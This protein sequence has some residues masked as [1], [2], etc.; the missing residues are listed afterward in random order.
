M[1]IKNPSLKLL[2]HQKKSTAQRLAKHLGVSMSLLADANVTATVS[3]HT[4]IGSLATTHKV[5][6]FFSQYMYGE[7]WNKKPTKRKAYQTIFQYVILEDQLSRWL[8]TAWHELGHILYSPFDGLQVHIAL[9]LLEDARIERLVMATYPQTRGAITAVTL[10]QVSTSPRYDKNKDHL[11][12]SYAWMCGKE[13]VPIGIRKEA[14]KLIPNTLA[15]R[16]DRIFHEYLGMGSKL[17]IRR[18]QTLGDELLELLN[19]SDDGQLRNASSD[20]DCFAGN[21][22]IDTLPDIQLDVSDL[23]DLGEGGSDTASDG[24]TG[25]APSTDDQGEP[26]NKGV[27]KLKLIKEKLKDQLTQ[28]VDADQGLAKETA[29]LKEVMRGG[30]ALQA[31]IDKSIE[32][33]PPSAKASHLA[34]E[35]RRVAARF[36]DESGKGL[37]R[38]RDSGRLKPRRYE[39]YDDLDIAYDQWEPGLDQE[40]MIG[41]AMDVS[42]SMIDAP[43]NEALYA[44]EVGLSDVATV[45]VAYFNAE[46]FK[47]ERPNT[48]T[49][50]NTV[51]P[52]GGTNP[53]ETVGYLH[54][55][56]TSNSTHNRLLVIYTDGE[57]GSYEYAVVGEYIRDLFM[58]GIHVK[59]VHEMSNVTS[60]HTLLSTVPELEP[61]VYR[62][63]G[64]NNLADI[65]LDWTRTVLTKGS[66]R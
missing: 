2:E 18:A 10:W 38:R 56:L 50:M 23:S 35:V 52:R 34:N 54:G 32:V 57:W 26:S 3:P 55:V 58:Q 19:L 44:L 20:S 14:R 30:V 61:H 4:N 51:R 64:V 37:V 66:G 62:T 28:V 6:S 25:D 31:D 8:G 13:H 65:V 24:G 49:S 48:R 21:A 41:I 53:A 45:E 12:Y 43:V 5:G 40:M 42:G 17:D 11:A 63:K 16:I 29:E 7:W 9:N 15:D 1:S 59:L 46:M 27:K 36:N 39:I 22:N 47:S 60:L 33:G